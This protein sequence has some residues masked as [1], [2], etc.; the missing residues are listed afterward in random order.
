MDDRPLLFITARIGSKRLPNKVLLPFWK[1]L[2]LLEFLIERLR[3]YALTSH[4]IVAV[5]KGPE[6]DPV[7]L[8]GEKLSIPTVRGP[9]DNVVER[10]SLGSRNEAFSYIGR[11][12]A[13]NPFTCPELIGLQL[14]EM[15]E[16]GADYSYCKEC[17]IGMAADL[18]TRECFEKT[19]NEATTAYEKEH[20]NAYVWDR[21][22]EFKTLWFRSP[23]YSPFHNV[24][25]SIDTPDD[26]L[27]MKNLADNLPNPLDA[28]LFD[29]VTNH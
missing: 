8:I 1:D 19:A 13:D 6:N 4:L 23:D 17:P 7:A 20:V 10:M 16:K 22:G 29:L 3:R 11:I 18:W 26:Y 15:I 27:R 25:L 21:P 2:T 5:P 24:N 28:T 14:Y 12:T 9:E